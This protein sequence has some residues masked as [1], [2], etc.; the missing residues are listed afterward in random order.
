MLRKYPLAIW[1]EDNNYVTYGQKADQLWQFE[2]MKR[3]RERSE[4]K[5]VPWLDRPR[6][7]I[8]EVFRHHAGFNNWSSTDY[9]HHP[10]PSNSRIQSWDQGHSHRFFGEINCFCHF[11]EF[12]PNNGEF[13][14]T[15]TPTTVVS[16]SSKCQYIWILNFWSII[17]LA[18]GMRIVEKSLPLRQWLPNVGSVSKDMKWWV[19][20]QMLLL[21]LFS[22]ILFLDAPSLPKISCRRHCTIGWSHCDC[23]RFIYNRWF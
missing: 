13:K 3:E 19:V 9:E 23:P 4:L 14:M 18:R 2:Y 1:F 22:V 5:T 17:R 11:K 16:R 12:S 21:E 7:Q 10:T 20:S 15:L 6:I 8:S